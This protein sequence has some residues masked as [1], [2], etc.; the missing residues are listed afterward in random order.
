M[1]IVEGPDGAGKSTLVKLLSEKLNLPVAA[2]VVS[3]DTQPMTD[4]VAWTESN[5]AAGF[6]RTIFDRHRLISEPIYACFRDG[7][8]TAS[9]MDLGWLAEQMWHFYQVKPILIYCLPRL[10]TV[11]ANVKNPSTDN[12]AVAEWIE[13][14]YAGY[15]A[16]AA[17]DMSRGLVKLYNYEVTRAD[18]ILGWVDWKLQERSL[19]VQHA[20]IPRQSSDSPAVRGVRRTGP[21]A[22]G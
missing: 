18:D 20:R 1:I 12:G 10:Q 11:V 19:N 3:S 7:D 13:H 16:R 22:F 4:L 9:F 17:A 15:V 21:P 8:P 5:V 6:Q 14:I 2:K